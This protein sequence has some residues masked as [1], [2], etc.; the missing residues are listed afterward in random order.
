[1]CTNRILLRGWKFHRGDIFRGELLPE[2][3]HQVFVLTHLLI[4]P[5]TGNTSY[6]ILFIGN[7][8]GMYIRRDSSLDLISMYYSDP[9]T[10][11]SA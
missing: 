4:G 7:T 1:M 5:I 11:L 6:P 9:A 2:Y 10:P 3:I 8:A